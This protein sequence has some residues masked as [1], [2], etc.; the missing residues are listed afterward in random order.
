MKRELIEKSVYTIKI[1]TLL[2]KKRLRERE[3]GEREGE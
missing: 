3:G 2:G 1:F